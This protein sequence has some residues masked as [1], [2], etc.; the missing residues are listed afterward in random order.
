MEGFIT[1]PQPYSHADAWTR[2]G[3]LQRKGY[4]TR[5]WRDAS[6]WRVGYMTREEWRAK[7]NDR[8]QS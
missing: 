6:G 4:V 3:D 5:V 1:D 8:T 2:A 7:Q